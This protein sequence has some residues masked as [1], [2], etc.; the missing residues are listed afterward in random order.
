MAAEE[1]VELR[2]L[3]VAGFSISADDTNLLHDPY[4]SRP[5]IWKTLTSWYEPDEAVLAPLFVNGSRAHELSRARAILIGKQHQRAIDILP[6][7]T[8]RLLQEQQ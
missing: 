6:C 2:W 7:S 4:L 8:A 1:A 3:G 5:G